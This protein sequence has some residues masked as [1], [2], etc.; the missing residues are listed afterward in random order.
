MAAP[1]KSE[2]KNK[3]L[4]VEHEQGLYDELRK[5]LS[6]KFDV[7]FAMSPDEA[8]E[9]LKNKPLPDLVIC[10][11]YLVTPE[12][13]GIEVGLAFV[14]K[15]RARPETKEI[16]V[17][18]YTKYGDYFRDPEYYAKKGMRFPPG[19]KWYSGKQLRKFYQ[20]LRTIGIQKEMIHNKFQI[21]TDGLIPIIKEVL[22]KK[23]T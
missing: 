18:I 2:A 4:V 3:I 23:K 13:K 9:Y 8:L 17:R 11:L 12:D 22:A 15:I 19:K 21:S 20:N 16:P 10:D 14:K 5:T 1:Q 6:S 7:V